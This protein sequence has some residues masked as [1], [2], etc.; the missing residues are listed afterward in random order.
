MRLLRDIENAKHVEIVVKREEFLPSA[1]ALYTYV[2]QLHKKVSLVCLC[3]EVEEKFS[4]NNVLL[5]YGQYV[6]Y[7]QICTLKI[8]ILTELQPS[9]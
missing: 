1:S 6:S 9:Y 4:Y 2:L 7:R 3:E 5:N 8:L